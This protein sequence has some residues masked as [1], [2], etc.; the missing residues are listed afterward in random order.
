MNL[1]TPVFRVVL[2]DQVFPDVRLEREMVA[3]AGGELVVAHDRDEAVELIKDADAV[4]NTYMPIGADL[5]RELR[6]AKIIAR[7]G[8]GVDNID[9]AAARAAGIAVTNVPDYCIEEVATHTIALVLTLLRRIPRS[10]AIA[11]SGGWG[12]G[13]LGQLRRVSALTIGLLGSG[14]IGDRVA[15][16]MEHLGATV[17]VHDPY[18]RSVPAGRRLVSRDELFSTAN[19]VSV[20]CPLTD[21]TRG[22]VNDD[23]LARMA[24][25]SYVVNTS[26]GPVVD[27]AA[28]ARALRSGHLAGAAL[29]VLDHEPPDLRVVRP[30][31]NLVLSPH[32]AFLSVEALR[33]SQ[34]K[35]TTQVL[36][37]LRGD[38]L[39]YPV[40]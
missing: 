26:R 4:L 3:A 7:Y 34:F 1:K 37:A 12:V 25:G 6:Q 33:E 19:V 27:F 2:T 40:G 29:D 28:V 10:D 5:V 17:I 13:D 35:A 30:V 9:V 11:R 8:I 39:D 18:L 14:R 23:A 20:H 36:K 38:Q 22:A 24:A 31:P 15:G 21:E 16:L 32:S